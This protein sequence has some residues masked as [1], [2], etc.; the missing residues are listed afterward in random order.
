[1]EFGKKGD[2]KGKERKIKVGDD[3]NTMVVKGE[4]ALL[5]FGRAWD[6][7]GGPCVTRRKQ[8]TPSTGTRDSGV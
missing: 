2:K 8:A 6:W 4:V 5:R 3:E 7:G 1:M